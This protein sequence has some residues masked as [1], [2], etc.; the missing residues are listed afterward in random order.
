MTQR[1]WTPTLS[2]CG[3]RGTTSTDSTNSWTGRGVGS[4][5]REGQMPDHPTDAIDGWVFSFPEG[6]DNCVSKKDAGCPSVHYVTTKYTGIINKGAIMY[7]AGKIEADP[8]VVWNYHFEKAN[9]CNSPARTHV[10]LQIKN[11]DLTTSDG[12]YW[13]NPIGLTLANG[14]FTL[15]IPVTEGNW[16][17]VDGEFN[18]EGF[19]KL[20]KNIGNVGFTFGGGCFFGHGVSV[21]DSKAKFYVTNFT[22]KGDQRAGG[23]LIGGRAP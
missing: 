18:K 5:S 16:I 14:L 11:D 4:P 15:K 9:V 12:R 2:Y 17:N 20:L 19:D 23:G 8:D 21:L 7:V 1:R 10:M 22:I 3:P 13:S 6:R